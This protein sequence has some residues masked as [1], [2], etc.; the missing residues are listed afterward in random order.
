MDTPKAAS[1]NL[2]TKAAFGGQN[3]VNGVLASIGKLFTATLIVGVSFVAFAHGGG[4]TVQKESGEYLIRLDAV[5]A[6]MM[7]GIAERI[8]FEIERSDQKETVPF[9]HVWVRI[10][11]P[12]GDFLFAGNVSAAPHG[13]VTGVSYLFPLPGA[14]EIT[15][16]F[17][18]GERAVAEAELHL[19]VAEGETKEVFSGELLRGALFFVAGLL[20]GGVFALVWRVSKQAGKI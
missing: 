14:Y 17:L 9:T 12:D 15:V 19:V 16:R 18:D 13:F 20:M 6:R 5:S 2:A 7:S 1:K 4:Q 3:Q 8:N 11:A 10:L